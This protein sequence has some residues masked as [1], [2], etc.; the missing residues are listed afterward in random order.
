E[1]RGKP[2]SDSIFELGIWDGGSTAFWCEFFQPKKLV[3]VD[4]S[5]RT[6][7]K[8]FE[9]YIESRA[10]QQRVKT[11]WG[12]DQQNSD[13]LLRISQLEFK[14]SLDLVLDDA[15]HHYR[16]TKSSFEALFPLIRPGGL[17]IIE[18]WAWAHWKEF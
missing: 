10:L 8:Y 7:S 2:R 18:D 13:E 12:V 14:T 15:S 3:A 4:L 1:C 16:P 5:L 11:Y 6:D 17:Y 9:R